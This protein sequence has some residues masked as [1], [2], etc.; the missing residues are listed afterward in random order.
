MSRAPVELS[1]VEG[2]RE[3]IAEGVRRTPCVHS[4][5]FSRLCKTEVFLKLENR[6]RTGS[7]KERGALNR[8]LHLDDEQKRRGIITASAGNHAQALA[9]HA[10]RVGVPTTVVMPKQ[11]PLVKVA[12]T[13][14]FGAQVILEGDNFDDAYAIAEARRDAEGL[15]FVPPFEDR[16]IIAGQ[17]TAALEL[18]EQQPDL[19]LVVVPIGGGGLISGMAVAYRALA[20]EVRVIGVQT[21]RIPSMKRSLEEGACVLMESAQTLADGIAV[22]RPGRMTLDLVNR[23]VDNVVNVDEEE[24]ASAILLL[25]EVVAA[26]ASAAVLTAEP[27]GGREV[28]GC[29]LILAAGVVEATAGRPFLPGVLLRRRGG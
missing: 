8:I 19:D 5:V 26:A 9:Y 27:F 21:E 10:Q 3:R 15:T 4:E 18:I 25:L 23:Y 1:D 13:R 12:N 22:K 6:H 2:A 28:L 14:G 24:I 17:G 7:F 11:T 16:E 29:L 20:P